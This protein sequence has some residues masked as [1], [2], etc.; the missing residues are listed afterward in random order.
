MNAS[1]PA[2][3]VHAPINSSPVELRAAGQALV[4]NSLVFHGIRAANEFLGKP[5]ADD[6]FLVPTRYV[7]KSRSHS[8]SLPRR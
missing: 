2:G 1:A 7:R 3:A 5:I 8:W 4:H 6:D